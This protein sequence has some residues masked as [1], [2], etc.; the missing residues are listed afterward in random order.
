MGAVGFFHFSSHA[1]VPRISYKVKVEMEMLWHFSLSPAFFVSI[2]FHPVRRSQPHLYV[3]HSATPCRIS[4]DSGQRFIAEQIMIEWC[5]IVTMICG[6]AGRVLF[7]YA[8]CA[9]KPQQKSNQVK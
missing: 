4:S 3:Q 2:H 9:V 6:C 1:F 5:H 8:S 7:R